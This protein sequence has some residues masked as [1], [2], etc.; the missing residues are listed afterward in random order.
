[1]SKY[2]SGIL[3]TDFRRYGDW[4]VIVFKCHTFVIFFAEI[5][6]LFYGRHASMM[7]YSG[8]LWT[9]LEADY[10]RRE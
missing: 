6:L 5:L 4:L 10:D 2:Y 9:S 3:D 7:Q 1:M 8:L